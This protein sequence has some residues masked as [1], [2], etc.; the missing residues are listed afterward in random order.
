MAHPKH[1]LTPTAPTPVAGE[2]L[3]SKQQI[4]GLGVR[5]RDAL[6]VRLDWSPMHKVNQNGKRRDHTAHNTAARNASA[7]KNPA[8]SQTLAKTSNGAVPP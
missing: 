5:L 7:R 8:L 4:V 6:E 2:A 1:H 3:A